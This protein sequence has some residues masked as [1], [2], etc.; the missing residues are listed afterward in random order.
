MNLKKKVYV[1][2]WGKMKSKMYVSLI[3]IL[4][5]LGILTISFTVVGYRLVT[6]DDGASADIILPKDKP[7]YHFVVVCQS[8]DNPFWDSVRKGVERASKDFNVGV[9]FVGPDIA[10]TEDQIK[11]IDIAIA[12]RV[13]GIATYAPDQIKTKQLINKAVD[14][15]IPVVT[16]QNDVQDSNR[17][18]FI[19]ENTYNFCSELGK[20][21]VSATQ[22]V[23][24]AVMLINTDEKNMPVEHNLMISGIKEVIKQYPKI[25]LQIVETGN[26]IVGSEDN[27]RNILE[28]NNSIDSIICTNEHDTALVAQMLIDLNKVG[29]TVIGHGQSPELLRYIQ[30]GI[31]WGTVT[32]NSEKM[33]YDAVKSLVDI[34]KN[35]RTSAYIP[36]DMQ[37][38]TKDNVSEYLK[39]EVN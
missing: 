30:K 32:G 3:I 35:G 9:E 16:I 38:I 24:N 17:T 15:G 5:L 13:D 31:I 4:I 12:S 19:G 26:D 20:M 1:C 39:D 14:K 33:G 28:R 6:E 25:R 22:G 7:T 2:L 18:T 10:N 23:S 11:Y 8:I 21:L 37:N 34:K 36:G 29:Y 27:I